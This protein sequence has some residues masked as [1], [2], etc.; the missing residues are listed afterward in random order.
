[1]YN[2]K[3]GT[4]RFP[5]AGAAPPLKYRPDKGPKEEPR[6]ITT[7]TRPAALLLPAPVDALAL[8]AA[9]RIRDN[10]R[11]HTVAAPDII[12]HPAYWPDSPT[13]P[14]AAAV[15]VSHTLRMLEA[16]GYK[17]MLRDLVSAWHDEQTRR[18]LPSIAAQALDADRAHTLHSTAAA[19]LQAIADRA[20][21]PADQAQAAAAAAAVEREAAARALAL[22]D[23]LDK[24]IATTS[25]TDRAPLIQE[26]A[27]ALW[28]SGDF[29]RACAAVGRAI[30]ANASPTAYTS[31]RTDLQPLTD[32]A[33]EALHKL[34]PDTRNPAGE[35][36]PAQW[37]APKGDG[38]YT[39]E[40]REATKRRPAGW[41]LIHHR[42]TAPRCQSYEVW[43]EGA[44][45]A[46]VA[47]SDIPFVTTQQAAEDIAALIDRASLTDKERQI[48]LAALDS[49]A[50]H[51]AE[52]AATPQ[53]YQRRLWQSAFTR[54][55]IISDQHQTTT[56]AAIESKLSETLTPAQ[57]KTVQR[58]RAK[59]TAA[60]AAAAKED[61][62]PRRLDLVA[63]VSA[64]AAAI[65]QGP[66]VIRWHDSGLP[67]I[68][69]H[70]DPAPVQP[71]R[72]A[73]LTDPAIRAKYAR[74]L[75]ETRRKADKQRTMY[76]T[77]LVDG[78]YRQ[79]EDHAQTAAQL[80][81]RAAWLVDLLAL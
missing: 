37:P 80:D 79:A 6:M 49:T 52:G 54:A 10:H 29:G 20:A 9:A 33:G 2:R 40:H 5:P 35:T 62:Q 17:P 44:G 28:V 7:T 13:L 14:K 81:R 39:V 1:M 77:A 67:C 59:L 19:D 63:Q 4:P 51:A 31:S 18:D 46:A 27:A 55:G 3:W 65:P 68:P 34:H 12:Q 24:V 72:P 76:F 21:T 64:Q 43:S 60:K 36:V 26:A 71:Q 73:G 56:R 58:I 48:L 30:R 75:D 15:A 38:Y 25:H 22:R 45:A 78:R 70:H 42:T 61:A 66:A 50:R 8:G 57:R 74:E 41:Y 16:Y 69:V 47:T 11:R 53:E 32:E 23:D